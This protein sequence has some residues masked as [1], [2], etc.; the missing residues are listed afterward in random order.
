MEGIGLNRTF[1]VPL[2]RCGKSSK[3]V[4]EPVMLVQLRFYNETSPG[5]YVGLN[6]MLRYRE[7]PSRV[8][9]GIGVSAIM[10][11]DDN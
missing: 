1:D 6:R 11:T 2:D 5:K 4:P 7:F 3:P 9:N 8:S 10:Q